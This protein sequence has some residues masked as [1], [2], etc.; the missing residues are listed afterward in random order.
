[1]SRGRCRFAGIVAFC[2]ML[3]LGFSALA[4]ASPE[5][6]LEKRRQELQKVQR[7]I[8]EQKRN[9]LS[10]K[11]QENSVTAELKRLQ[12][13]VELTEKEL[14]YIE[15]Q[16]AVTAR[17]AEEAEA[18]LRQAKAEMDRRTRLMNGRLRALYEVGPAGYVE[19]LLSATSFSDFITRFDL[20]SAIISHDVDLL[21]SIN[22]TREQYAARK[23]ELDNR[24]GEL[25]AVRKQH[26]AKRGQ[27]ATRTQDRSKFLSQIQK[28]RQSFEKALDELEQ[29]SEELVKVIQELQAESRLSQS[30]PFRAGW[31]ATGRI[32]SPFGRRL[33]PVTRRYRHHTGIDIAVPSGTPV[34]A[35]DGGVVLQSGWLGGYGKTVIIDHGGGISTLYAHNSSVF[36]S[37]GQTVAKGQVIAHAGTTG[38]STGPHV[39]FEIREKGTPVDPMKHLK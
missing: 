11:R 26:E 23:G 13:Q 9:I 35:S 30:G 18:L 6:D 20:L 25:A 21:N 24:L 19:V 34:K 3:V 2:L 33:H 12:Q 1:M 10:A 22:S 8:E 14:R 27:F 7:E 4:L 5:D 38:V 29:T 17:R 32:S 39:H 28:E 31:P 16:L 36:V 37:E 15:A